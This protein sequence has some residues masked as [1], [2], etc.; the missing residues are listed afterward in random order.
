ME[1]GE[2]HPR[3]QASKVT[4][5]PFLVYFV[6][7]KYYLASMR[8]KE[9][10]GISARATHFDS[11]GACISAEEIVHR[12]TSNPRS[13][14]SDSCPHIA[15]NIYSLDFFTWLAENHRTCLR[16]LQR[17]WLAEWM[18]KDLTPQTRRDIN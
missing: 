7:M 17:K 9:R 16:I 3:L 4:S 14:Q 10:F 8:S 18:R 15:A 11:L 2:G 5:P 1:P 6:G 13:V 12:A